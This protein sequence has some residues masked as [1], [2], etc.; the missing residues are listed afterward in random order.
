MLKNK[1]KWDINFTVV[2][3]HPTLSPLSLLPPPWSIMTS[4]RT[5]QGRVDSDWQTVICEDEYIV[6]QYFEKCW[7]F[8][9]QN[10][11]IFSDNDFGISFLYIG[12]LLPWECYNKAVI[13]NLNYWNTLVVPEK[14][15][16]LSNR[17]N[18]IDW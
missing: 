6:V 13:L 3:S 14:F 8:R 10:A 18:N 5:C 11:Q 15:W 1:S 16:K 17:F 2:W 7:P 9:H 4:H 12:S